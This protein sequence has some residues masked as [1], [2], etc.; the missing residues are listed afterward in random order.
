MLLL[1]LQGLCMGVASCWY[2]DASRQLL[3]LVSFFLCRAVRISMF[4]FRRCLGLGHGGARGLFWLICL[5]PYLFYLILYSFIF[6]RLHQEDVWSSSSTLDSRWIPSW[7]RRA[8]LFRTR[9]RDR[10]LNRFWFLFRLH[11]CC[12]SIF[13]ASLWFC[14]DSS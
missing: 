14:N 3:F 2:L 11:F 6:Q 5:V 10:L 1:L 8:F 4:Y 13:V 12:F 7:T 9:F